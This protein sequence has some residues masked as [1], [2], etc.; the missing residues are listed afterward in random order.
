MQVYD[1][2]TDNHGQE[3]TTHGDA[4]FP[5]ASYDE[6]FSHF[7]N[8][9]VP[10]H[11]HDEVEVVFVAKGEKKLECIRHSTVLKQGEMVLINS[12]I[13]HRFTDVGTED[14]RILNVLFKPRLF[15]GD[16]AS[17]LYTKYVKPIVSN[18]SFLFY[19]FKSQQS[20]QAEAI[21]QLRNGFSAWESSGIGY[22]MIMTASLMQCWMLLCRNESHLLSEGEKGSGNE[23]RVQNVMQFIQS[24]YAESISVADISAAAN[25]SESE[26]YRMFKQTLNCTPNGY[27]MSYRLRSAAGMLSDSSS[28]VTEI[29]H[30]VGFSCPAYFAKKFRQSYGVSPKQYRTQVLASITLW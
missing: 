5:C 21:A 16:P 4:S 8:G 30:S 26:C 12:G 15:G 13:L 25:I 3:L 28:K 2:K 14:C 22:E 20:W 23:R 27:L 24:H 9:E 29:A 6:L 17:L 11:W 1:I 7:L 18:R 19:Q 10:W